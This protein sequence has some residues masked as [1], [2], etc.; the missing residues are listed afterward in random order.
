MQ[1]F[2][3]NDQPD[4]IEGQVVGFEGEEGCRSVGQREG[5]LLVIVVARRRDDGLSRKMVPFL[6]SSSRGCRV[7]HR[8]VQNMS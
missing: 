5:Q 1:L 8:R 7:Y 3:Y 4:V 6:A 2:Y